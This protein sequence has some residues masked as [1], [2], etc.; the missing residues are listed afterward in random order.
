MVRLSAGSIETSTGRDRA[1]DNGSDVGS[2]RC[3]EFVPAR[4][5]RT[6]SGSAAT[7]LDLIVNGASLWERLGKPHNMLS[8]LCS[9]FCRV[10]THRPLAVSEF[11]RKCRL[12]TVTFT[13]LCEGLLN[14]IV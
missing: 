11:E 1:G 7:F 6:G 10:D 3:R 5:T 8:V 13:P 14:G 4:I 2:D 9:E 12:S